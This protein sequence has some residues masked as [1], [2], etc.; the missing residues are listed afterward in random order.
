MGKGFHSSE[1]VVNEPESL[2]YVLTERQRDVLHLVHRGKDNKE[3]AA[4]LGV[5]L[6]TVKQHLNVIFQRLGVRNRTMA[7]VLWGHYE[8]RNRMILE[9]FVDCCFMG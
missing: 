2:V 1:D 4:Q 5:S 6:G 7:A 9:L 8:M 3:I